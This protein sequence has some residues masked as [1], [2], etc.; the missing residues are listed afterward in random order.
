MVLDAKRAVFDG[1]SNIAFKYDT[2]DLKKPNDVFRN[3]S[4]H[5]LDGKN[6]NWFIIKQFLCLSFS[7][8]GFVIREKIESNCPDYQGNVFDVE[9]FNIIFN[10]KTP[11]LDSRIVTENAKQL[12]NVLENFNMINP[13]LLEMLA[14][15]NRYVE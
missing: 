5:R 2:H 3:Y 12:A 14:M 10:G 15:S 4:G 7:Y 11:F 1:L 9:A 13:I 8:L 6:G